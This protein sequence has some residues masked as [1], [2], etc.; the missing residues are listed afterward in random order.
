MG[1]RYPGRQCDGVPHVPRNK[2]FRVPRD[3][4]LLQEREPAVAGD[5]LRPACALHPRPAAERLR[6]QAAERCAVAKALLPADCSGYGYSRHSLRSLHGTP[7]I[8][9]GSAV[10]IGVALAYYVVDLLFGA[11]GNVNY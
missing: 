6:H 3:T 11:M 10:A 5:E 2:L 4:G 7:R 8:N 1:A 9:H